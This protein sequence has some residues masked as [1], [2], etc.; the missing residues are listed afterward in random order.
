MVQGRQV[1]GCGCVNQGLVRR[2]EGAGEGELC[3]GVQAAAVEGWWFVRDGRE[4]GGEG[5]EGT[6]VD[7]ARAASG[8][9]TVQREGV[10]VGMLSC[11]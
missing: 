4:D 11:S 5:A 7:T 10:E 1:G 6:H 2:L 9:P 8:M 3:G